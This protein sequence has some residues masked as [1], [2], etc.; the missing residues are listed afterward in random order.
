M[1]VALSVDGG[2]QNREAEAPAGGSRLRAHENPITSL[3]GSV[4]PLEPS[5]QTGDAGLIW[6]V[7]EEIRDQPQD[8][9]Q[10]DADSVIRA[11]D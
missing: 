3:A 7:A 4:V 6:C 2:G 1:S 8:V 5:G 10:R 11:P 9:L